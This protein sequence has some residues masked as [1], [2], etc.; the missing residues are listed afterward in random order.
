[1]RKLFILLL[2]TVTVTVSTSAQK[3]SGIALTPPMGWNS[4][5]SFACNI[6]EELIKY[7]TD[8]MVSSG[9]KDA[10]YQ[11]VGMG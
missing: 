11:Y 7:T 4:W 5:N 3:F 6:D 1:M 9:M 10:G 2:L 8:L